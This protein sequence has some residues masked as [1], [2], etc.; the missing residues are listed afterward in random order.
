MRPTYARAHC[1]IFLSL[2]DKHRHVL[3]TPKHVFVATKLVLVLSGTRM[4][5]H[6]AMSS[7]EGQLQRF[8]HY[9]EEEDSSEEDNCSNNN[10]DNN[11]KSEGDK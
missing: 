1:N 9:C 7:S 11:N 8:P 6:I 3:V 5:E 2:R 4:H 10:N